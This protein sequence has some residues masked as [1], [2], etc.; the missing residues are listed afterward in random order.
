MNQLQVSAAVDRLAHSDRGRK[1]L[2]ALLVWLDSSGLGLDDQN[3][4]AVLTIITA[5]WG[6]LPMT[7]RDELRHALGIAN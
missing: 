5:A 1:T 7:V 4:Q 2:R 3:Q 6:P